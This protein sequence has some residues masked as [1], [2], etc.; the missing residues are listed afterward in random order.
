LF[1]FC[2]FCFASL[3]TLAA[4]ER[5]LQTRLALNSRRS[6]CFCHLAIVLFLFL[7]QHFNTTWPKDILILY[8]HAKKMMARKYISIFPTIKPWSF[9]KYRNLYAYSIKAMIHNTAISKPGWSVQAVLV[10]VP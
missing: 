4:L 6:A 8:K 5:I 9:Y 10:A 1:S 2:L 7:S 3:L